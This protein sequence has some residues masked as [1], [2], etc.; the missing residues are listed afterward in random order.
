MVSK[1]ETETERFIQGREHVEVAF[2]QRRLYIPEEKKA[3]SK[4][5][6]SASILSTLLVP[7]NSPRKLY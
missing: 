6:D 5:C 7:E 2:Q 3:M 1:S 4:D